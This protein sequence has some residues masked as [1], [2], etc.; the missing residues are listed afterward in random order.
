MGLTWA[1]G[2]SHEPC[3]PQA[4]RVIRFW[5]AV[6]VAVAVAEWPGRVNHGLYESEG[7]E[8]RCELSVTR[9][10]GRAAPPRP[11]GF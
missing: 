4:A 8:C 11:F 6:A 9:D 2:F 1:V 5:V 10:H 3:A 7:H